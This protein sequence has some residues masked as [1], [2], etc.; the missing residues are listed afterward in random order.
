AE[1][2][3]SGRLNKALGREDRAIEDRQGRRYVDTMP[4]KAPIEREGAASAPRDDDG[5]IRGTHDQRIGRLEIRAELA[6]IGGDQCALPGCPRRP[7]REPFLDALLELAVVQREVEGG[8]VGTG[9][10]PR[11]NGRT[12][13]QPQHTGIHDLE[14]RHRDQGVSEITSSGWKR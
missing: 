5:S 10:L 13:T 6:R 1:V 8:P 7:P 3:G 2:D 12:Q 9:D 11:P 14:L 4:V